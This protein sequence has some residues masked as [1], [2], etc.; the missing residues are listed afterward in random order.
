M[1]TYLGMK[2]SERE[3]KKKLAKNKKEIVKSCL[4]SLE[5][6]TKFIGYTKML[7]KVISLKQNKNGMRYT[8]KNTEIP[9]MSC[10]ISSLLLHISCNF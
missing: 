1:Q 8:N 3:K 4:R 9:V 6:L 10:K 5:I 2:I 7:M